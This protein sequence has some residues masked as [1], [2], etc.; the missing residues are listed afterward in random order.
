MASVSGRIIL[1]QENRFQLE[2]DANHDQLFILSHRASVTGAD[3]R[4]WQRARRRITVRY[5]PADNLIAVVA[6]SVA[7]AETSSAAGSH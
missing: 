1:V 7:P 6:Q 2:S 4:A 3:L 5:K